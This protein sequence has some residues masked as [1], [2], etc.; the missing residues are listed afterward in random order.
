M[1]CIAA[2]VSAVMAL[3][4]TLRN[5]PSGVSNVDTPSVVTSRYGVSS[6]PSG[7]SSVYLNSVAGSAMRSTYP[8]RPWRPG[9]PSSA[10][11]LR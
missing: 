9:S 1:S 3:G 8:Q 11:S 10:A 7:N 2:A 5:V 6:G 4:S